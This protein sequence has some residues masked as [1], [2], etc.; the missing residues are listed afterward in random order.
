MAA[1]PS[2]SAF[3]DGR[4]WRWRWTAPWASRHESTSAYKTKAAAVAAGNQW[5]ANRQGSCGPPRAERSTP[6]PHQIIDTCSTDIP[7]VEP[8]IPLVEP[9]QAPKRQRA[10]R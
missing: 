5:L 10:R 2:I 7:L 1:H 6:A 8:D 9:V 3:K 4:A